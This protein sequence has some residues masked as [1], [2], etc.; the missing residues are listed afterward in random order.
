MPVTCAARHSRQVACGK[1]ARAM[2]CRHRLCERFDSRLSGQIG[3][4]L[5]GME[6]S[7]SL[8]A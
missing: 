7:L 2:C 8:F 4:L 1:N 6:N 3:T 5:A